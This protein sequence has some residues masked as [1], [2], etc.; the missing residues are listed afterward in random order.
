M[1][2]Y[3]L[4]SNVCS[5]SKDKCKDIDKNETAANTTIFIASTESPTNSIRSKFV[6]IMN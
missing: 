2:S 5:I 6:F 4:D 3:D 1:L